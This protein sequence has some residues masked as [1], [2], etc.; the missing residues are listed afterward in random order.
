MITTETDR[1]KGN[2]YVQFSQS[3][4]EILLRLRKN[5]LI[6]DSGSRD[7]KALHP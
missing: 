2:I 3:T 7:F 1:K 5:G 6:D 4:T